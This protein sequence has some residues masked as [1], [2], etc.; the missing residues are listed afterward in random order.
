MKGLVRKTSDQFHSSKK[1][2]VSLFFLVN[3][4]KKTII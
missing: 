4:N 3:S 1:F 2:F